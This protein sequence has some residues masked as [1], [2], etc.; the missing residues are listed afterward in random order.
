MCGRTGRTRQ[1]AKPHVWTKGRLSPEGCRETARHAL[2]KRMDFVKKRSAMSGLIPRKKKSSTLHTT[3]D[4]PE[5]Q[6]GH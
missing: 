3:T 1:Q 5:S 6:A 2:L 4:M